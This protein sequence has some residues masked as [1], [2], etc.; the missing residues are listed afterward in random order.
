MALSRRTVDEILLLFTVSFAAS[1]VAKG[2][3]DYARSQGW[4][5]AWA[6][7]GPIPGDIFTIDEQGFVR[8][9]G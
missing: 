4:L 1:F 3:Y 7:G 2:I 6:V 9:V 8:K 5:P